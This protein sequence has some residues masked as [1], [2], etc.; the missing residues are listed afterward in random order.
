MIRYDVTLEALRGMVER[1][2]PGWLARARER[3]E[4][5]RHEGKYGEKSPIWK[6]VKPIFMEVQGEGK[7]C[8]CERKFESGE[9][10]RHEL[11]IEHFRP[12]KRIRKW[13]CPEFLIDAMIAAEVSQ[14]PP[15]DSDKGYHLLP[16]HLLNYAVACKP[17]N[18][19]LKKDYFPISGRYDLDGEDP[20]AM[21]AEKP[22]LLY[23]IGCLDVDPEDVVTFYGYLPQSKSE[24][25]FLKLRGLVTIA[26]F[27]LDDVD[28]RKNLILERADKIVTLHLLLMKAEDDGNRRAG[29]LVDAMLAS[30][31][32]HANYA[33]SFARLFR[34]DRNRADKV[35]DMASEFLKSRS[36]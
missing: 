7:C 25:Q 10:G 20:G 1:R 19:G 26:F 28:R 11:D 6:D 8:F 4:T 32:K 35:A 18:S 31:A 17:C 13:P 9:L 3:T 15:P 33:R 23:P 36:P 29:M 30:N 34:S 14:T 5:F 27:G 24:D 12:K 21:D 16:Y 22:W 2:V